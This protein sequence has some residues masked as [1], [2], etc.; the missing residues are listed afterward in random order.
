MLS[1][2]NKGVAKFPMEIQMVSEFGVGGVRPHEPVLVGGYRIEYAPTV[3]DHGVLYPDMEVPLW[4]AYP[5]N[6]EGDPQDVEATK[7]SHDK[8]KLYNWCEAN[9][10]GGNNA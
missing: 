7:Y 10:Y 1:P 9:P 2:Y 8:E 5:L 3:Q 4:G 6:E